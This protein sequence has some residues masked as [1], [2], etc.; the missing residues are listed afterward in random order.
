MFISVHKALR[1]GARCGVDAEYVLK[2]CRRRGRDGVDHA[3]HRIDD[4]G[5]GYAPRQKGGDRDL[6]RSIELCR[7]G[8]A[9][10]DRGAAQRGRGKARLVG[11]LEIERSEEQTSELQS[12]MRITYTVLSLK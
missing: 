4:G 11:R 8:A 2:R 10:G 1:S 6:V 12:L 9:L 3:A 5:K 7:A